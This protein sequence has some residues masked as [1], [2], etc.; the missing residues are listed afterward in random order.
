MPKQSN[1]RSGVTLIELLVT[2]MI[3]A[4]AC[5]GLAAP[6][7]AE[8]RF[9]IAGIAQAESQRDAQ[10][11][12]RALAW[13]AREAGQ[14]FPPAIISGGVRYSFE[15]PGCTQGGAQKVFI[16]QVA[17]GT[18]RFQDQCGPPPWPVVTL[19]SGDVDV[20]GNV[21]GQMDRNESWLTEFTIERV[22][23]ENS[24]SK[25]LHLIVRV[26]HGG[27]EE[28]LLETT[29]FLRNWGQEPA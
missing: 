19:I 23:P 24:P 15:L 1:A 29:L 13:V 11:A 4:I 2:V 17:T 26:Q 5:L 16:A 12:T 20:E 25:I 27:V 10:L 6:M 14:M 9:W 3:G 28:E 8:R 7:M 22:G 18:L 21:P